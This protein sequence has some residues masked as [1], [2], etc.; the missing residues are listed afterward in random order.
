MKSLLLIISLHFIICQ[1][2]LLFALA[3]LSFNEIQFK[4]AETAATEATALYE[5]G[6]GKQFNRARTLH[7]RAG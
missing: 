2:Q 4:K 3:P 5:H 6:I 1:T 7:C